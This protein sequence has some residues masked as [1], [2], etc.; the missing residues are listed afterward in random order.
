MSRNLL[1][2]VMMTIAI[3]LSAFVGAQHSARADASL[4]MG[5]SVDEVPIGS[6]FSGR[7]IVI[8][9]ALVDTDYAEI[10]SRKFDVIIE[11]I[12]KQEEIA[13]RKKER[14]A[15]IWV[16]AESRTFSGVPS[17]Y[18]VVANKEL[19][20]IADLSLLSSLGIGIQHLKAKADRN[21]NVFELLNEGEFNTALRRKMMEEGL[22]SEDLEA[23]E[24]LS[25]FLF[26]AV[27]FLPPSIPTGVHTVKAHLFQDGKP[28]DL[29]EK[30][31]R[32]EKI[33]FERWIHHFAKDYGLLHGF[34]AVFLAIFTG[35]FADLVFRRN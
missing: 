4:E 14:V 17:F 8:F 3:M 30:H 21:D 28:I 34:F 31:F 23:L 9:G 35:W 24:D 20:D 32:V 7:D 25:P 5:L 2:S 19:T 11:V 13:V 10:F 22:F 29:V 26:R 27:L 1:P 6:D 33:G 12:G 16:N 15:G 18:S